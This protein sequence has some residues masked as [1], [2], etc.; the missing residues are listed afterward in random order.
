[1]QF[2]VDSKKIEF[3]LLNY[4]RYQQ[5]RINIIYH[6]DRI[7]WIDN[8]HFLTNIYYVQKYTWCGDQ[9]VSRRKTYIYIYIHTHIYIYIYIYIYTHTHIFSLCTNQYWFLHP[10]FLK[11]N[12]SF[13]LQ[14]TFTNSTKEHFSALTKLNMQIRN[15]YFLK[16]KGKKNTWIQLA[17]YLKKYPRACNVRFHVSKVPSHF[18]NCLH[19]C[20]KSFKI[21]STVWSNN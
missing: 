18:S 10:F 6:R 15:T 13:G 3:Y 16:F 2:S 1:M 19:Y 20:L 14:M 5:I 11:I 12:T 7:L 21:T 9:V 4:Q 8:L 17:Y